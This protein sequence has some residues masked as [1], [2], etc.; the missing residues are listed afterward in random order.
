MKIVILVQWCIKLVNIVKTSCWGS[1]ASSSHLIVRVGW[2]SPLPKLSLTFNNKLDNSSFPES[3]C[4]QANTPPSHNS[5]TSFAPHMIYVCFSFYL[6]SIWTGY[7]GYEAGTVAKD[8]WE[9]GRGA[10]LHPPP[11]TV[12]SLQA[13]HAQLDPQVESWSGPMVRK[14]RW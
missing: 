8:I 2:G 7:E 6:T 9:V 12:G 11:T 3:I 4:T 14:A 13:P 5:K 1:Q 10:Q